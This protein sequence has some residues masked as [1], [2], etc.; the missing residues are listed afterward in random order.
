MSFTDGIGIRFKPIDI[1][2]FNEAIGAYAQK[3]KMSFEEAIYRKLKDWVYRASEKIPKENVIHAKLDD[4]FQSITFCAYFMVKYSKKHGS[5]EGMRRGRYYTREFARKIIEEQKSKRKATSTFSKVFWLK[6]QNMLIKEIN[7]VTEK[8]NQRELR[9]GGRR[10]EGF[11]TYAVMKRVL[12]TA[13]LEIAATYSYKGEWNVYTGR[14]NEENARELTRRFELA[15]RAT[16][17][18]VLQDINAYLNK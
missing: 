13:I 11:N 10:A 12:D 2:N 3:R 14:T 9:I 15:L 4:L 5:P 17:P 16:L 18:E 7:K 1:Q 8:K 6:V